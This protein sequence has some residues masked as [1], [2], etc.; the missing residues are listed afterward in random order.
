[1]NQ[2]QVPLNSNSIHVHESPF[3]WLTNFHS[4]RHLVLPSRIV[5]GYEHADDERILPSSSSSSPSDEFIE[6]GNGGGF[7]DNH[8]NLIEPPTTRI[9]LNALHVGC[10]TST[11]GESLACLRENYYHDNGN[12]TSKYTLQYRHIINVDND[13][14]ALDSMKYRWECKARTSSSSPSILGE[15]R[16]D[17][18]G[19]EESIMPGYSYGMDWRHLD[20][21]S[22]ESCRLA[23][24]DVYR[25][26]WQTTNNKDA[27]DAICIEDNDTQPP[28]GGCI[29]LVIDKSTL[30]CLLCSETYV[31]AQFLCEIYRALRIPIV[32]EDESNNTTDEDHDDVSWGGVYVLITFHPVE[33]VETLLKHL[34]GA[35]W[36]VQYQVIQRQVEDITCLSSST[37]ELDELDNTGNHLRTEKKG[38]HD[39]GK[40]VHISTL[41]TT[42]TCAWSSGTFHP[43][44]NYR[45]TVN[46]FSCRRRRPRPTSNND[47]PSSSTT[48]PTYILDREEVRKHIEQTCDEW[49]RLTNPIVTKAREEQ[50]RAAFLRSAMLEASSIEISSG[51]EDVL[52]DLEMCYAIIFTDAEKEHLDYEH[53]LEDWDAYCSTSR[54]QGKDG[55]SINQG[56]MTVSIAL[57]FLNEM[58]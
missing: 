58:Q 23:L 28:A 22:D 27:R 51:I 47:N 35:D 43:D 21:A 53:F 36:D 16:G 1:M 39:D 24:D 55:H 38:S 8:Q 49:Y 56:G 17:N 44:D 37:L 10:G 15:G 42:T 6:D 34:P 19:H 13:Q 26:M 14:K 20:F 2:E 18:N 29:D 30:D 33:F 5:F 25:R 50:L 4:L 3:E 52:L 31:I 57:D 41:Q 48:M 45:R 7:D 12:S 11:L 46:A 54:G 9:C 32:V 40:N